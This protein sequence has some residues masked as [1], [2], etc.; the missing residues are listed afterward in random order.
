[1]KKPSKRKIFLIT[2]VVITALILGAVLYYIFKPDK[3]E[4]V[5]LAKVEMGDITQTLDT[6]GTVESANQEQ[7]IIFDGTVAKEVN[8][9]VGDSVKK[10]DV[11]ATFDVSSLRSL[12]DEK[13]K[14]Y[15]S[16]KKAYEDYISSSE[17]AGTDLLP[18]QGQIDELEAKVAQL[19]KKVKDDPDKENSD[20]ISE[21]EKSSLASSFSKLFGN[22]NEGRSFI[23]RII[24]NANGNVTSA[25]KNFAGNAIG[26]DPSSLMS[27]LS[28]SSEE[29]ELIS[30]QI[31]LLKL[32]A[33]QEV[34]KLQS[35]S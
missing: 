13:K 33:Q 18:L 7:Y 9:A 11:L 5:E 29:S 23:E 27:S 2:V 1:M 15:D 30:A 32:K 21:E 25:L 26:F 34:L 8:V 19:E 20:N 31:E 3:G 22:E 4:E 24:K 12:V 6:S 16:A 28:V 17:K 14:A 35:N 10:G